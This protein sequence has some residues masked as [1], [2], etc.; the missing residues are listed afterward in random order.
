[1]IL[2]NRNTITRATLL[3]TLLLAGG[4][5]SQISSR[6]GIQAPKANEVEL[7]VTSHPVRF[8]PGAAA[9][10]D[11][12]ARHLL[13]FLASVAAGYG[14]DITLASSG[15]KPSA[16]RLAAIQHILKRQG[17]SAVSV[18]ADPSAGEDAVTLTVSR[19]TVTVPRCPDWSTVEA[20]GYTNTPPSNFGCATTVNLGLMVA[21]PRDLDRGSPMGGADADYAAR[22]VELYRTGQISSSLRSA[23]GAGGGNGQSNSGSSGSGAGNNG[24][25]N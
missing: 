22:S 7:S 20:D 8:A 11:D 10:G 17:L 9:I 16:Q 19:Y 5:A 25:G 18:T 23:G 1:M 12:E 21:N 24:G 4:C 6:S 13:A 2:F 3:G 15:Q 14:D